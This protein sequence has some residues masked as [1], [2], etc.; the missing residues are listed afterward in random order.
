LLL[1]DY[2]IT[3]DVGSCFPNVFVLPD[4]LDIIVCCYFISSLGASITSILTNSS[5]YLTAF[6]LFEYSTVF[7]VPFKYGSVLMMTSSA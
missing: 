3:S 6:S 7:N 5:I 1:F 2:E 4:E